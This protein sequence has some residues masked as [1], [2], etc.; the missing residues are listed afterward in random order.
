MGHTVDATRPHD[1][2]PRLLAKRDDVTALDDVTKLAEM[3][4]D[5]Q[6]LSLRG[7]RPL[8]G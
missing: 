1:S 3:E 4:Y 2:Q 5:R 7:C 6:L 8:A